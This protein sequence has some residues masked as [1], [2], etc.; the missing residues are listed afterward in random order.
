MGLQEAVEFTYQNRDNLII[1][2]LTGR[3]GSGCT[4]VSKILSSNFN[5]L[6]LKD[7]HSHDYKDIEDRKRYIIHKYIKNENGKRWIPFQIIEVSSIILY[8]VCYQGYTKFENY[9]KT[10]LVDPKVI[11]NGREKLDFAINSLKD[12]FDEAEQ[13]QLDKNMKIN[14]SAIKF[15]TEKIIFFRNRFREFL[16]SYDLYINKAEHE[17]EKYSLY[18]YLMQEFANNLRASGNPYENKFIS[19]RFMNI[20][21]SI[22]YIIK[23][24]SS[25][26]QNSQVRICI[27]AI[28]NP[29]EA[30]YL[31]DKY[32]HFYLLSI[33]ADDKERIER[34]NFLNSEQISNLD[35][36]EYLTK[37]K[38]PEEVF[39]HQNLSA[40]T[41]IADIHIHNKN[42]PNNMY[43][44]LT[45]Q[46]LKYV[47]LILHPGLITP[48]SVERCMQMAYSAKLNSGCLSR[49]VGAVVTRP[50]YSIQAVGWNDV[51]KG[52]VSCNLRD[53][54]NFCINKDCEMFSKYELE[55][56]DFNLALEKIDK[57]LNND[58]V[59]LP[60]CFKDVYIGITG[61][62]NQVHT[63]ALHAEENAFLQISKYG[64]ES[65][66]GGFLFSTAS[67]CELCSKKAYQLGIKKIYYI[68]PY[69]GISKE[70]ILI[71]GKNNNPEMLLF[72]G[73][74]GEAYTE[75][76]RP[77]MP[78]KDEIE[79]LTGINIKKTAQEP[80][81]PI[82]DNFK[83]GDLEYQN[84]LVELSFKDNV[85]SVETKRE[86]TIKIMTNGISELIRNFKWT[87]S[88]FESLELDKDNTDKDISLN[89]LSNKSPYVYK[90]SF[91]NPKCKG[92]TVHY[93]AFIRA[94]DD[95]KY[96]EPRLGH[97]VAF[98]TE[99]LILRLKIPN[100]QSTKFK[101]VKKVIYADKNESIKIEEMNLDSQPNDQSEFIVY[102]W[103][104]D[105]P[106]VNY[107]YYI[108]WKFNE[109]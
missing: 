23:I 94:K 57:K 107:S 36:V 78:I 22:G 43:Y 34:L 44:D 38:K 58:K 45:E 61:E 64:G 7:I 25:K 102:E 67:P 84:S 85:T 10:L 51:P 47:T 18:T 52:Q 39:Y 5:K 6:K 56:V 89:V 59:L 82:S 101:D 66:K 62:K 1:L 68:D 76:F 90:L 21:E 95:K 65:I 49:Q 87:E 103:K 17:R 93:T 81:I 41:E 108:E 92:D 73:A 32:K 24:I 105:K 98:K 4:T 40:C 75:L 60:Y 99:E 37:P 16:S 2:G 42:V 31:R 96:M 70:H 79:M 28:R 20:A 46:L 14:D 12:I 88:M 48:S 77:K 109:V 100:A 86:L 11:I 9:I 80:C 19:N 72:Q 26:F 97:F 63:R 69:P 55:N 91:A 83:Y 54:H 106:N 27:D 30:I 8:K 104:V 33:N 13:H 29:Y 35:N 74:I 50:D 15:F 71:F 53:V 3:T